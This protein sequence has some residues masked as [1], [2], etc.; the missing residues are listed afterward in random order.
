MLSSLEE[1]LMSKTA[2]PPHAQ[3]DIL[4]SKKAFLRDCLM[5]VLVVVDDL[6]YAAHYPSHE[7][8]LKGG[9][10]GGLGGA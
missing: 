4:C 5:P 7:G 2:L 6:A 9:L 1:F 8:G 10:R 3:L